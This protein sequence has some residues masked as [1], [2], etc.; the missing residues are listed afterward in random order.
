MLIIFVVLMQQDVLVSKVSHRGETVFM[1]S[2]QYNTTLIKIFKELGAQYSA[3]Y[4]SWYIPV[5]SINVDHF[6]KRLPNIQLPAISNSAKTLKKH[7]STVDKIEFNLNQMHLSNLCWLKIIVTL[8][9][10]MIHQC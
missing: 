7:Y 1:F 6:Q 2:F 9:S 10:K 3:T 5:C 8:L 4:K